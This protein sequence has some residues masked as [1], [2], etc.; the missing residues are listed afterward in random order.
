MVLFFHRET[1]RA[2]YRYTRRELFPQVR[3]PELRTQGEL[4]AFQ[5]PGVSPLTEQARLP[6]DSC[7]QNSADGHTR[8]RHRAEEA[9][10]LPPTATRDSANSG[11]TPVPSFRRGGGGGAQAAK[12][13]YAGAPQHER[14]RRL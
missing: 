8:T 2:S 4:I 13:L 1:K 12:T 10:R 7:C 11:K 3:H 9:P 5:E 14:R 6:Q